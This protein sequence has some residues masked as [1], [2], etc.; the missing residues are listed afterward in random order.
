MRK[1]MIM[2]VH[3]TIIHHPALIQVVILPIVI[4]I[5]QLP[6]LVVILAEVQPLAVIVQ[7]LIVQE[8]IVQI[9]NSSQW[10]SNLRLR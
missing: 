1:T 6:L 7:E 5:L 8:L 10:E 4:V 3:Q 9:S 2:T